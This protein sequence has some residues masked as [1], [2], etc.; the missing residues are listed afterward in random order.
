MEK[1]LEAKWFQISILILNLA[2]LVF[3]ITQILK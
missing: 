3:F 2:I 1:V